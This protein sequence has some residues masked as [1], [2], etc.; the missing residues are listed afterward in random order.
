MSAPS[1][2]PTS[3]SEHSGI[4]IKSS[5]ISTWDFVR[6]IFSILKKGEEVNSNSSGSQKGEMVL[7]SKGIN[8]E[9]F[10]VV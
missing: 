9:V 2:K 10:N 1:Q 3:D 7:S 8:G 4:A 5:S 6:L